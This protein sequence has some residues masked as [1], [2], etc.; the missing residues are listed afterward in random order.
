MPFIKL[1]ANGTVHTYPYSIQALRADNPDTSFP[2]NLSSSTDL[3]SFRV[4]AVQPSERPQYNANTHVVT[5]A[6][7][8]LVAGVWTQQWTVNALESSVAAARI[9]T[10]VVQAV[11]Q[12]L[13]TFAQTANY[14]SILSACT[15]ATSAVPKFA[16]E[17]QRA[18]N[19]RDAT[20]NA[21]YGIL[22]D[23]QAGNRVVTSYSDIEGD[24]PLLSWTA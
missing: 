20:W 16:A 24:L 4:Y 19:L 8:V 9:Q 11:Q 18:V 3:A 2:D 10:S 7:P 6:T 5:E 15:Y 14:D 12:R 13:D 17:G 22:A 1:K 21:L 23:V